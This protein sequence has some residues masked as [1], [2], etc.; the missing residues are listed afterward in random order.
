MSVP[1]LDVSCLWCRQWTAAA[2][3]SAGFVR[4]AACGWRFPVA[5]SEPAA[6]G[7][8]SALVR[9]E[10]LVPFGLRDVALWFLVDTATGEVLNYP[11]E[12]LPPPP[13]GRQSRSR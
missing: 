11:G 9:V 10:A 1:L 12:R 3:R 2:P 7:D 4:C 6:A 13:S 5:V 8:R